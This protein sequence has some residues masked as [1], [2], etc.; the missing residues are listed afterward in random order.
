MV[1]WVPGGCRAVPWNARLRSP[2]APQ[3][4]PLKVGTTWLKSYLLGKSFSSGKGGNKDG[5]FEYL[6]PITCMI[7][8]H[9]PCSML[10]SLVVYTTRSMWSYTPVSPVERNRCCTSPWG[11]L[12]SIASL[13]P[14]V[15]LPS[16]KISDRLRLSKSTACPSRRLPEKPLQNWTIQCRARTGTC[17]LYTSPSPRDKRQSRMP[18]SA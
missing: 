13:L 10:P 5:G 18:S 2:V 6:R 4:A 14:G 12:C 9:T 7:F 16:N 15:P 17:L 1:S 3:S 8:H 11:T